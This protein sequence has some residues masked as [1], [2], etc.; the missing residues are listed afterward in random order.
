MPHRRVIKAR[1]VV[2]DIRA[3]LSKSAL[4]EK[5][6]LSEKGFEKVCAQLI[7]AGVLD[8]YEIPQI[9]SLYCSLVKAEAIRALDRYYLDFDLPVYEEDRPE[10]RGKVRDITLEGI[11]VTGLEARVGERKKL[12]V[13]RAQVGGCEPFKFQAVCR[14]SKKTPVVSD[15]LAGFEITRI[16]ETDLQQLGRLI[17]MVTSGE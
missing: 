12:V 7:N 16:S 9:R 6:R 11:G 3:G 13:P 5:Y 14:W 4:M 10:K 2:A 17:G 1:E 8:S 15:C